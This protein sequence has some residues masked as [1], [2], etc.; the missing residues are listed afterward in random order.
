[1]TISEASSVDYLTA[2]DTRSAESRGRAHPADNGS[3]IDQEFL[4]A[5]RQGLSDKPKRLPCKYFY[6]QRGSE[7]F[8]QIC[9]LPEYYPT[10]CETQIMR[11]HTRAMVD[12]IEHRRGPD[13]PL[14]LVELGSGSSMKTRWLLESLAGPLSYLP[15]DISADHLMGVAASLQDDFPNCQVQPIAADFTKPLTLP[16]AGQPADHPT[17]IY[18]PGSTIGNFEPDQAQLL[19]HQIGQW[20]P[21]QNEAM[22]LI[23]F[24][25]E[26]D[27]D[28]LRAAYD[29]GEGITARFN[30]NL[31]RRINLELGGD[32]TLSRFKHEARYNSKLRRIEMHLVSQ[33]EQEIHIGEHRF[34]LKKGESIHTENSHK[35][36]RERFEALAASAGWKLQRTWT[37][38]QNFF[39]VALFDQ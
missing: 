4:Q 3:G 26:K 14:R 6:D 12:A 8:D 23:G 28:I 16:D 32:F 25:L 1:M 7:L 13:C 21:N 20:I 5:V 29:D 22:L 37:D 15:I 17:V 35:Y 2:H 39:A 18:F 31:L 27:P 19:L 30:L 36:S 33:S 11:V 9:D 38:P 24:D 10:R 34:H